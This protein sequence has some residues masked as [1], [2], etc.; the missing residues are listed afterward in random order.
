M[1]ER[2]HM[3]QLHPG[4][5]LLSMG[6]NSTAVAVRSLCGGTYSHCAMWTGRTVIESTTPRVVER[7][8]SQSLQDHPR[9]YVDVY[10]YRTIVGGDVV[11]AARRYVGRRYSYGNLALGTAVMAASGCMANRASQVG[12]LRAACVLYR[13]LRLERESERK[14]VTCAE[15]VVRAY[16]ASGLRVRIRA[17]GAGKFDTAAVCEG[18]VELGREALLEW[19]K[20]RASRTVREP[21]SALALPPLVG[22]GVPCA[23]PNPSDV[24]D[25]DGCAPIVPPTSGHRFRCDDTARSSL[26]VAEGRPWVANLIS[27]HYLETSPDFEFKGRL[28]GETARSRTGFVAPRR[29]RETFARA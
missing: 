12:V 18:V 20:S 16:V 25:D 6:T 13:A 9:V 29:S 8:L 3:R 4:D 19:R 14:R 7:P 10:R 26:V 28:H 17:N 5:I 2:I 15:L 21:R 1:T 11:S 23:S 22:R 27:P 24:C